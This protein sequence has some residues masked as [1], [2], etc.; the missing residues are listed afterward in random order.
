M[1]L[2]KCLLNNNNANNYNHDNYDNAYNDNNND[3]D[4]EVGNCCD[5]KKI[6]LRYAYMLTTALNSPI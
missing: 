3:N 2:G 5:E 6:S 1:C 4:E